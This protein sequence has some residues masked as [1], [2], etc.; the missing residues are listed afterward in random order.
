MVEISALMLCLLIGFIAAYFVVRRNFARRLHKS[1]LVERYSTELIADLDPVQRTLSG[2]PRLWSLLG[3]VSETQAAATP[4][5]LETIVDLRDLPALVVSVRA[6]T[7]LGAPWRQRFR[8]LQTNSEP[9]WFEGHGV[10]IHASGGAIK[11]LCF[12]QDVSERQ[13]VQNELRLAHQQLTEELML[14]SGLE[15]KIMAIDEAERTRVGQ[16]LHDGLGQQLTGVAFLAK[17]LERKLIDRGIPESADATWIVRLVNEAISRTRAIARGLHAVGL[18]QNGLTA[19]LRQLCQDVEALYGVKCGFAGD[20][21]AIEIDNIVANHLYRIAQEAVN[22]ALK[23]GLPRRIVVALSERAGRIRLAIRDDGVGF[24]TLARSSDTQSM[25]LA[26]MRYRCNLIGAQISIRTR[27]EKGALVFVRTHSSGG[28]TS[29]NLA[30]V[31]QNVVAINGISDE[32]NGKDKLE[33]A[34]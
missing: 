31:R 26:G 33:A 8:L 30:S 3:R 10:P 1:Q 17:A 7:A 14:K 4:L 27:P 12:L 23:H 2:C 34:L 22:N 15:H 18:E 6:A 24:N 32:I 13:R 19:A 21:F 11:Y 16:E 9:L 25:G 5:D 20:E 29:T 28:Y